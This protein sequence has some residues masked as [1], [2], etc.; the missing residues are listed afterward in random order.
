M[1]IVWL[2]E[3]VK[4]E[5]EGR[6]ECAKARRYPEPQLTASTL[7]QLAGQSKNLTRGYLFFRHVMRQVLV[8]DSRCIY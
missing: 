1:E 4:L 2:I 7:A 5:K 6:A 8:Q 3:E